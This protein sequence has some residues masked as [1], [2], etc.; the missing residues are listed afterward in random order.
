MIHESGLVWGAGGFG[1]RFVPT[2][3]FQAQ[4]MPGD[5]VP[6]LLIPPTLLQAQ[7]A[8]SVMVFAKH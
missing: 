3:V 8:G 4:W 2:L 6:R 7:R 5:E 1:Q